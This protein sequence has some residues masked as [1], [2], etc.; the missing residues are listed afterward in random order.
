MPIFLTVTLNLVK[1][2]ERKQIGELINIPKTQNLV[3]RIESHHSP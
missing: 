3:K 1:R 2:I